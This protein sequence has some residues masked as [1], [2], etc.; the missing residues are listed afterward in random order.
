M[1]WPM[2]VGGALVYVNT[3]PHWHVILACST[4]LCCCYRLYAA[5]MM[6]CR[7][8]GLF[9][10]TTSAPGPTR[11]K[12]SATAPLA[13]EPITGRRVKLLWAKPDDHRI[14]KLALRVCFKAPSLS[15]PLLSHTLSSPHNASSC[16]G[17][18]RC[19]VSRCWRRRRRR[20]RRN[21]SRRGRSK[22][23]EFGARAAR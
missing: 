21:G 10:Y 7:Y 3:K 13:P 14:Q 8:Q 12:H 18:S 15:P 6:R 22:L 9:P 23:L 19:S 2:A 5:R 11:H 1:Q 20:S 17:S 4:R 16:I